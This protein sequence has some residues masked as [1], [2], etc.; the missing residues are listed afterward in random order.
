MTV[1]P[2][3]VIPFNFIKL[4][5]TLTLIVNGFISL[6]SVG[7]GTSIVNGFTICRTGVK[8]DCVC[9]DTIVICICCSTGITDSHICT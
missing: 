7:F 8:T 2:H 4:F 6:A 5:H 1:S 9:S 3:Q